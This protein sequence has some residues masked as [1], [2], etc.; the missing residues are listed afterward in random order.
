[1]PTARA[2]V[3]DAA[4][5]LRQLETRAEQL[6]L[7]AP[8]AGVL[9]APPEV[10]AKTRDESR[11]PVWSGAPL[12]ARNAGCWIEPGTVFGAIA[13]PARLKV[14]VAIDQADV[15]EVQPGQPVRILLESAPVRV[16]PGEV[17]QVARRSAQRTAIDPA[18]EPGKYHLAEV[19]L[20]DVDEPGEK[21]AKLL[22]GTRGTAKIAAQRRTLATIVARQLR[23]LLRLPW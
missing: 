18:V 22:I 11:L 19:R 14:L 3:S 17:V 15:A 5:Q 8:T 1:M 6:T 23:R 21:D 2:A 10:T 20:D 13:D 9:V 12:D 7:R 16:L 4:A